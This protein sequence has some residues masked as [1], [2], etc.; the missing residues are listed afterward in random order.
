MKFDNNKTKD[1]WNSPVW[2]HKWG[3]AEFISE[4]HCEITKK[5]QDTN[6]KL[7]CKVPNNGTPDKQWSQNI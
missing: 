7:I 6:Y 2:L 5:D 1:L 3:K 4:E